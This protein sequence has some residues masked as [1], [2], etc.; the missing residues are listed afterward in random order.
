M[1][2]ELVH[3]LSEGATW[4]AELNHTRLQIV[5]WPFDEA[6][7]LLVMCQEVVPERVLYGRGIQYA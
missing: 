1:A 4:L 5:E 3:R 2:T 6:V 7:L